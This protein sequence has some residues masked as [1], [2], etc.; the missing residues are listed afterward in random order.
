[1]NTELFG[2]SVMASI[3]GIIIVFISLLGLSLLMVLLKVLFQ[4]KEPKAVPTAV[5]SGKT[6]AA[7]TG[8]AEENQEGNDWIMAAVAAYLIQE[9]LPAPSAASWVSRG[10]EVM[11]PWMNRAAFDRNL[12]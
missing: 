12:V 5:Q 10:S 1:M 4:D 7:P 11:D 3:L 9:D 6:S 8:P 2:Y